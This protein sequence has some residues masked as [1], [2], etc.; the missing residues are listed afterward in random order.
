[1]KKTMIIFAWVMAMFM[2]LCLGAVCISAA[3]AGEKTYT[4]TFTHPN[5]ETA[6]IHTDYDLYICLVGENG[7]KTS[8]QTFETKDGTRN[9]SVVTYTFQDIDIG[10]VKYMYISGELNG[11]QNYTRNLAVERI[12]IN[13]VGF[14]TNGLSYVGI[15]K[16]ME[17]CDGM[18]SDGYSPDGIRPIRISKGEM[19]KTWSTAL[20]VAYM[21]D[22]GGDAVYGRVMMKDGSKVDFSIGFE[23]D[24]GDEDYGTVIGVSPDEI[25]HVLLWGS[26]GD[27]VCVEYFE[28]WT[29]GKTK[30]PA[31]YQW[32][33][34]GKY[35]TLYPA[36]MRSYK[37]V[38]NTADV[39]DAGT[40]SDVYIEIVGEKGSTGFCLQDI[41]Y[42]NDF[43]AGSSQEYVLQTKDVGDIK[44][45][46]FKLDGSDS[47][48]IDSVIAD[49]TITFPANNKWVD[50]SEIVSLTPSEMRT[51]SLTVNTA[52]FFG[53]GTDSDV[54]IELVGEKGTSGRIFLDL[55]WKNDFEQNDSS[56]YTF[57]TKDVGNV[58][59]VIF[60]LDG[61]D[62]WC[63]Q[64]AY[65]DGT[66]FYGKQTWLK[67]SSVTLEASNS[68][69]YVLRIE[70]SNDLFS[71]T[72]SDVYV[73]FIGD[74]GSTGKIYLNSNNDTFE[75][76]NIDSFYPVANDVGTVKEICLTLDGSDSWRIKRVTLDGDS[77]WVDRWLED[78]S[79]T[80]EIYSSRIYTVEIY[81]ADKWLAGTDSDVYIELI[82]E[83]GRTGI[84]LL[85]NDGNDFEAD[86]WGWYQFS[87]RD[88]G[89]IKQIRLK[90]D[91]SDAWCVGSVKIDGVEFVINRW[92][93]D[94]DITFTVSSPN[95]GTVYAG[96]M[97]S[98]GSIIA[99]VSIAVLLIGGAVVTVVVVNKRKA[100][101]Q[102]NKAE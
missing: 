28:I 43:E 85:D 87:E 20:K 5:E 86:T 16:N 44:Q 59:Q 95:G 51:Y 94:D 101:A 88:V 41:C 31:H 62:D 92:F 63:V 69:S 40:D 67:N 65:V 73:E 78:S 15:D 24:P 98:T 10:E 45:I 52:G 49:D 66:F 70:T 42:F 29:Q 33:D 76:G 55:P 90:L 26:S 21:A 60:T 91:G 100:K 25:D 46:N 35:I 89:E 12:D 71:G 23:F 50:G 54:Y 7:S 22:A 82:G 74:N 53:A 77:H 6:D 48:C 97:F 14:A 32:I 2:L 39:A 68:R 102:A 93:E 38:I 11:L 9:G 27:E 58:K 81:T 30:F 1:M 36:E 84:N 17:Y 34:D 56:N 96:S 61:S 72:N 37:L 8:L 79:L 47:W 18:S 13:G 3:D 80:F 83:N 75:A 4:I 99:I 64:H 57:N 19:P